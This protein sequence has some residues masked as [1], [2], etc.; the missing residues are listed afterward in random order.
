MKLCIYAHAF[1]DILMTVDWTPKKVSREC[2]CGIAPRFVCNV[3]GH[4]SS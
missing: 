2:Y 3:S 4:Y 1:V